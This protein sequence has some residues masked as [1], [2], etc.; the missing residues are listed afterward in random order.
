MQCNSYGSLVPAVAALVLGARPAPTQ[1]WRPWPGTPLLGDAAA[2]ADSDR[3]RIVLV[4]SPA[5]R[6]VLETWEWNGA[7]WLRWSTAMAPPRRS[8]TALAYDAARR[9]TIL[10]GGAVRDT[11]FGDTWAW[12]GAAWTQLQPAASPSPRWG[13][14]VAYDAAHRRV[15]LFG[16]LDQLPLADTWEWDGT[17]WT[18]AHPVHSPP[19]RVAAAMVYDAARSRVLLFGGARN[20]PLDDTWTWDGV[21][22]QQVPTPVAPAPRSGVAATYDPARQRVVLA[23]GPQDPDPW[24]PDTTWEWDG[25][26]WTAIRT[27]LAPSARWG[28]A[29]AY[30][31]V[32]RRSLLFGGSGEEPLQDTW[33]WDGQAWREVS[34]RTPTNR[35]GHAM[36]YDAARRRVVLF[37]GWLH[38][39][40]GEVA[41]DTW[42]WDGAGW[43]ERTPARSPAP[44]FGSGIAFDPRRARVV[45]FG[46]G[47]GVTG[48]NA[49]TWEWDGA[50]WTE[51]APAAS[52]PPIVGPAMAHDDAH[53]R[54]VMYGHPLS[55]P[56]TPQ[57]WEW[58]GTGWLQRQPATTPPAILV[59]ERLAFDPVRRRILLLGIMPAAGSGTQTWE[60]DGSTWTQRLPLHAP[61]DAAGY[62]L[63]PGGKR[64]HV[65]AVT[66]GLETAAVWE[67]NGHDW[68]AASQPQP[69]GHADFAAAYDAARNAVV[70]LSSS[71][72]RLWPTL[73]GTWL[74]DDVP[75]AASRAVGSGCAGS[76]GVPRLAG[77][78][79]ILGRSMTL[80]LSS[81]RPHSLCAFGLSTR[82]GHR[83]VGP[84]VLY[85]GDPL[86]LAAASTDS[87]GF[88]SLRLG[89]PLDP[90]L[91]RVALYAQA[92]VDEPG[93]RPTGVA[94]TAGL[95]LRAGE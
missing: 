65:L 92:F 30:D 68:L 72:L 13:A 36:A 21:D 28:P 42:E 82:R 89:L 91:E 26:R 58:D 45:L 8:S 38:H 20:T 55:S 61:P 50:T 57:T 67:W 35:L 63:V 75:R 59:G 9:R 64:R 85:L 60:W 32:R 27:P 47:D 29:M 83:P 86:A 44:R 18:Q 88:S 95:R 71:D 41:G 53:G 77:S 51:R 70:L 4:G 1:S 81:A 94:F 16:G 48:W 2:C 39:A 43:V 14:A 54:I 74:Y 49:D 3:G 17:S 34:A 84:C 19:A 11:N 87:L 66:R 52:P 46:G 22:W 7:A 62:V 93:A 25:A 12:D 33:T 15:V 23:G 6:P 40:L 76:A 69:L 79:P 73:G 24:G 56:S 10:F 78:D 31:A 37:G 90:T 80:D 5:D